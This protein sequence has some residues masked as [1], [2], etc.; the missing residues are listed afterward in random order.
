MSAAFFVFIIV[1]LR[2]SGQQ[3]LAK[4]SGYDV[5]VTISIGSIIGSVVLFHELTVAKGLTALVVLVGLQEVVRFAQSRNLRIHHLVRQEP[6][7]VVWNGVLL[8]NR[9]RALRVSADEIRG[10]LRRAGLRSISDARLVVLEND[11][12]WSVIRKSEEESDD[13]A[14]LGLPIPDSDG[15]DDMPEPASPNRIP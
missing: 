14:L 12:D 7:V 10:A 13:S 5:V 6:A 4:M 2:V 8:E 1:M 15:I 9:L 3:A 11:G